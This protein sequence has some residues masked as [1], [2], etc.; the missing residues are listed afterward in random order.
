MAFLTVIPSS[1][2]G[3]NN[4][5]GQ[6]RVV[7]GY[8]Y[9]G[10]G[11]IARQC[12]HPKRPRNAIWYKDKAMLAEA[13]EARQILDE[14]QLIFLA[15]PGV[16]DDAKAVL[17]A[18]ISNY[19]SDVISEVPH[20]ETYLNDMENQSMHAMQDFEKSLV[21][22][23]TDNEVVQIVLWYLDSECSKHMTGNRFQLMNFVSKF[24]GIVRFSNDHVA[25]IMGYG[26]Y[27]LGNVTILRVYY[28][29]GL[30][31]NLFSV[32]QFCDADL[33]VA[34]QKNT[35]F[36]HNGTEFVNQT[37]REFYENVGISH[38]TSVARTPQQN[39]I[40]KRRNQTLIEAARTISGLG[41]HSLTLAT[42]SSGLV[43]NTV[44]QQPFQ[45]AAAPRALVLADSHVSTSIDQDAPS[46]SIPLTQEQEHSPNISQGFEESPK[47]LSFHDD[48][49]HE[50]LH[51]D[52]TF[53]E[54]S[55][56]VRQIHTPFEHLSR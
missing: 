10:E 12:T 5:S 53:Q 37:L 32:C 48:P 2:S 23:F 38:Q 29:K 52:S 55:S 34:F 11:H 16:S 13:K 14:E 6:A 49:R 45:E 15:D 4:K 47:T 42:S 50:S 46:T 8:N 21:V 18:N 9:E 17:M 25:R 41:L 22:D 1:S 7:K 44:S 36:I 27:Q 33:E 51:E 54:S 28:V 24:L 56:N 35:C 26:D 40:V 20:S 43:P 19:G 31:H 3:G 39:D 30:G